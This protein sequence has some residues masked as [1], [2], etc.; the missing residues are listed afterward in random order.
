MSKTLPAKPNQP[1]T[2]S[3]HS[4]PPSHK[5]NSPPAMRDVTCPVVAA[6]PPT[7]NMI[8]AYKDL[9]ESAHIQLA[10]QKRQFMFAIAFLV[11][12]SAIILAFH[13]VTKPRA[14]ASTFNGFTTDATPTRV[15][16]YQYDKSCYEGENGEQV[17][18]TRT[19]EKK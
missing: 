6:N 16:H 13:Q 15:E 19:S 4:L 1:I 10:L 9:N 17:C 7:Q 14:I 2:K 5:Q 12:L 8:V 11:L 18:M 3:T